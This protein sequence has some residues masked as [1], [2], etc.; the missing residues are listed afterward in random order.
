[1]VQTLYFTIRYKMRHNEECKLIMMGKKKSELTFELSKE[2]ILA[3]DNSL[4]HYKDTGLHCSREEVSAWLK[5][6]ASGKK[7]P[8]PKCH[9]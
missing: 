1:M 7:V 9:K 4:K 3:S 6:W 8:P 2:I 5:T